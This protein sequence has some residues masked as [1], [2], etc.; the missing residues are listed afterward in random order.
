LE[1]EDRHRLMLGGSLAEPAYNPRAGNVL[2]PP[3]L[4]ALVSKALRFN[5]HD[6]YAT[7]TEMAAALR[8]GRWP[9]DT[10][11]ALAQEALELF[12]PGAG[13]AALVQ[14]CERLALALQIDP[15]NP[16]AHLARG[17]IY[18]RDGSYR[19]AVEEFSKVVR[20]C[21][22]RDVFDWLGQCYERWEGQWAR[23]V[24]AYE[25]ALG[26]GDEPAI[27]DRLARA[28]RKLGRPRRAVHVLQR[29]IACESDESLRQ[30]RLL[31]LEQW[32]D[33]TAA[34]EPEDD[35]LGAAVQVP[36][37]S[38]PKRVDD[39]PADRHVGSATPI[40]GLPETI[41]GG[42]NGFLSSS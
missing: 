17:Q 28:L 36:K 18:L 19:F 11:E 5:P 1:Q 32:H 33:G 2:V 7:A 20:I 27:L 25:Q 22:S 35:A 39:Q 12:P 4:A 8:A 34:G 14:A 3:R 13:P 9:Q 37:G 41:G 21:P 38:V 10:V 6:R 24:A 29:A 40:D 42:E 26:F 16:D 30:R 15:G 31:I 23:A